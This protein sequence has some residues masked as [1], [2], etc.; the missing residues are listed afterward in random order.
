VSDYSWLDSRRYKVENVEVF[1]QDLLTLNN[2]AFGQALRGFSFQYGANNAVEIHGGKDA[3]LESAR[4]F[5]AITVGVD[6]AYKHWFDR[7][8]PTTWPQKRRQA[9]ADLYGYLWYWDEVF[10]GYAHEGEGGERQWPVGVSLLRFLQRHLKKGTF[11]TICG[12]VHQSTSAAWMVSFTA[13]TVVW[14]SFDTLDAHL[15]HSLKVRGATWNA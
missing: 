6:H 9:H 15:E 12:I 14:G 5:S 2:M 13:D 1:K 4:N 3:F 10:V 8:P 7:V 11:A